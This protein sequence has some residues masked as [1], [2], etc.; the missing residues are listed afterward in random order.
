ME[1]SINVP[2]LRSLDSRPSRDGHDVEND[3]SEMCIAPVVST[4]IIVGYAELL[5]QWLLGQLTGFASRRETIAAI[6]TKRNVHIERNF[7][8]AM[9]IR[10]LARGC[11]SF[12]RGSVLV[13]QRP[14]T[15][16]ASTDI[17]VN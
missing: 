4:Q 15:R 6:Y 5:K 3:R 12:L 8:E 16:Q 13:Q 2:R 17:L 11:I 1:R 10:Q 9:K 14:E 7:G